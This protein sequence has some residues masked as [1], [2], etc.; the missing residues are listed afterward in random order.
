MRFPSIHQ[1]PHP[2]PRHHPPL[3]T[4]LSY[5]LFIRLTVTTAFANPNPEADAKIVTVLITKT[6]IAT[7]IATATATATVDTVTVDT[8]TVTPKVPQD[9][10]YTSA[11]LFK[12][13]VLDATNAYRKA[14]NASALS[15]NETLAD[16]ARDWAKTCAWEHSGAPYGENLAYGYSTSLSS[17]TAWADE[18]AHYDFS[19]PTGFTEETGHFTQLVWKSTKQVGC[20]AVD[21][22]VTDLR[23]ASGNGKAQGWYV[24]CEYLPGGNIVGATTQRGGGDKNMY[25]RENVQEEVRNVNLSVVR[26]F[27]GG[28]NGTVGEDGDGDIEDGVDNGGKGFLENRATGIGWWAGLLYLLILV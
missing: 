11:K 16:F 26:G 22:G 4:L 21:C 28:G 24:V 2:H 23:G 9:K 18:A 1:K 17:I 5:L 14:Y 27:E 12:S 8:V 10:S 3:Q 15:W 13:T 7:E 25:F 19:K 20:A 6:A